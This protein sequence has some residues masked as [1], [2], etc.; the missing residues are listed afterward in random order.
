MSARKV[1][2]ARQRAGLSQPALAERIGVGRQTI[3][4]IEAGR[5]TP[6]VTIALARAREFGKTVEQLFGGER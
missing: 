4:R 1:A 2:Q 3:A 5:Q 6:S